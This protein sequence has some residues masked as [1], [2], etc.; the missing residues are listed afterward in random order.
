MLRRIIAAP[1]SVIPALDVLQARG[2]ELTTDEARPVI[3]DGPPRS[4]E[5]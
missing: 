4:L 2:K 3:A 5:A 1:M